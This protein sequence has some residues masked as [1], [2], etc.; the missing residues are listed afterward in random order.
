[1]RHR[2]AAHET[3]GLGEGNAGGRV[4]WRGGREKDMFRMQIG[5]EG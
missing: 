4:L 5:S 2:F 1:M 3:A